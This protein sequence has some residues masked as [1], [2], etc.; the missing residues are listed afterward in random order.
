MK[1][2][3]VAR[4]ISLEIMMHFHKS[5]TFLISLCGFTLLHADT[6]SLFDGKTLDGWHGD[7]KFWKVQDGIINGE[8]T[9][10]IPCKRSSYL[11]YTAQEFA[12]FELTFSFR[13]LSKNG[14]SGLQYRSQWKN[15]PLHQISGY[16]A[17]METGPNY[18]GILYEQDGRGIVAKRGQHVTIST[19]G[20]KKV[21]PIEGA[22]KAQ[23]SIKLG[24]WSHYRIIANGNKLTH[25]INGHTTVIVED[26][27]P[28]HQASKGLIAIQLHQGPAMHV[29]Y[30]DLTLRELPESAPI[31]Q[32]ATP[33]KPSNSNATNPLKLKTLPGFRVQQIHQVDKTT[34][35]SWVAMCF[36]DAG[37]LY[38]CDQYGKLFRI[39]LDKGQITSKVPVDS[40]GNAQGLCWAFGSLYMTSQSD[41]GGV[42]RLTDTNKDGKFDRA[43]LI[44]P[45]VGKGEH[46]PHGL[47]K[48]PDGQ[49][50]LL[51]L[52]NHTRQLKGMTSISSSN[53]AEDTLHPHQPDANG[54]AR[55]IKAPGG[56]LLRISSDG[57]TREVI[58]TGM[59]N[60]YDIAVSPTGDIFGFDSDM[61]WDLG[62]PWY[63]PTRILHLI[64]GGEY[65]WRTGTSKWPDYYGDSLGSV[66]DVGPGC[67]TGVLFGTHAKFPLKYRNAYYAL[68]WTFGIIYAIHLQPDGT[69]FRAEREPFV[70][71]KPLP[72]T[73]AVIGP[74]GAMYFIT[75]GRKL[76]SGL[77]R[78]DY[79]GNENT[80]GKISTA[81]SVAQQSLRK[82]QTS[83][84]IKL[85]WPALASAD[86]MLRYAARVSLETLPVSKWVSHYQKTSDPQTII[87]ASIAMARTKGN[88]PLATTKLLGLNFKE[89]P[90]TQKLGYLRAASLVFIRLGQPD[91][92]IKTQFVQ[93]LDA[94]YP[95]ANASLNREL[96]RLLIYLDAPQAVSKTVFLMQS[97]VAV[98][99]DIP[100]DV[101]AGNKHYGKAFL[102]M[103]KNQPD[104]QALHYALMLK[105]A[106]TG[107][108]PEAV[109]TYFAWLN[110]AESKSGGNSYK[111]F[112][113]NI[114][115]EALE[116]LPT[117]FKT[118]A[119]N[120]PQYK[121]SQTSIPSAKGPGQS[122]T[123]ESAL[124]A[125]NDL[126]KADAVNGGK[127]FQATLCIRCHTHSG[128]GGASGPELST[129]GNRF[130]KKDILT[131]IISPSE[132]ISEQYQFSNIH[133]NDGSMVF[134][135]MMR[136]D[137]THL[138]VAS[139]AF[140]LTIQ[141][142]VEKSKITKQSPA[143][144]SS[145]PPSLINALNPN[146][147][148]D[149][150]LFLTGK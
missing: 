21:S 134:G 137:D 46:G 38:V 79:T 148:R 119:E 32:P 105:N 66:D 88:Q 82:I 143:P 120:A 33:S 31:S 64:R 87:T 90:L 39:T 146:E 48:S 93:Q 11:T 147:L 149:L 100:T 34:E 140:D 104:T 71:G 128:K 23:A 133:L 95:S 77:F 99:E 59:R 12:N 41:Q 16:Q 63:R 111:G 40:P 69:S 96:C 51:V 62:T 15:Q 73:D 61:E 68:D 132:V 97:S 85:L 44:L 76:Q 55:G 78:V 67:P 65:G 53:W 136:E 54:H 7:K 13:F 117:E 19:D 4:R 70:S 25:Q 81:P 50:L 145:M 37:L 92:K 42:Y 80:E 49:G 47:V 10:A 22:E 94:S 1:K 30:K 58:A 29:Q 8:S 2:T 131:A 150:M 98:K 20:K 6:I 56:T 107:W 115:K 125:V 57:K 116:K 75:G 112:I 118:V 127:M 52:G 84:D 60:T 45:L 103:L 74:D 138:Y 101:L 26:G 130:S 129:L 142:A 43:K 124:A 3:P 123:M 144:V 121:K 110:K 135:K 18:S 114:R 28:R 83:R 9:A 126:S 24:E 139:S 36:D 72:L 102:N 89:L 86:R 108:T 109:T 141:T 27:D 113:N 35:G 14:N 122:W 5:L 17:D 91:D 106:S